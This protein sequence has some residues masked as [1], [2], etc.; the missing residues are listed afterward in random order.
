MSLR[1]PNGLHLGIGPAMPQP[2]KD[3]K[4]VPP[5][6][7]KAY[8]VLLMKGCQTR[9]FDSAEERDAQC[10]KLQTKGAGYLAFE[11]DEL[12]KEYFLDARKNNLGVS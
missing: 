6:K 8:C 11:Y 12:L 9:W 7:P 4:F 5:Q 2:I 10:A 1:S 3:V